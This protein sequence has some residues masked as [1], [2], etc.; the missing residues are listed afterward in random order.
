MSLKLRKDLWLRSLAILL[1]FT[2]TT[3]KMAA[4]VASQTTF[5]SGSATNGT[6]GT[7][8]EYITYTSSKGDGTTK[9]AIYSKCIRLYKPSPDKATGGFITFT[10]KEGATI[11]KVVVGSSNATSAVYKVDDGKLSTEQQITANGSITIPDLSASTVSVYNG[12]KS[13]ANSTRDQQLNINKIEITYTVGGGKDDAGLSFPQTAY[14][15][16]VG[17]SFTAPVATSSAGSTGAITYI[18]SAP[19]VASVDPNTG[20]VEILKRGSTVITATIAETETHKSGTTQYTLTVND[21]NFSGYVLVKSANDLKDGLQFMI[22]YPSTSQSK[23]MGSANSSGYYNAVNVTITDDVLDPGNSEPSIVTLKSAANASNGTPQWYLT[24]SDGKYFYATT[25]NTLNA[26]DTPGDDCV[27]QISFDASGNAIIY[28]SSKTRYL[29]YNSSSPRFACYLSTSNTQK[30]KIYADMSTGVEKTPVTLAFEPSTPVNMVQGGQ[31]EARVLKVT[32]EDAASHVRWESSIPAIAAVDATSGAITMGTQLGT[33]TIKAYIPVN[34]DTYKATEATYTITVTE[35]PKT[36]VTISFPA[37]EYSATVGAAFESP[38][39]TI[40]PAGATGSLAYTSSEPTVASVIAETGVVTPLAAGTTTIKATFTGSGDYANNTAQYVLTVYPGECAAPTFDVENNA[41]VYVGDVIKATC[42]TTGST[43]YINGT[44]A[45]QYTVTS[46][47]LGTLTLTAYAEVQG[48]NGVI[49]SAESSVTL[50]VEDKPIETVLDKSKF[51]DSGLSGSYSS[52]NFTIPPYGYGNILAKTDGTN[53]LAWNTNNT[54]SCGIV[55]N[56][57]TNTDTGYENAEVLYEIKSIKIEGLESGKK[58]NVYSSDTKYAATS[59]ITSSTTSIGQ[60]T[61]TENTYTF[62]KGTKF[63]GLRPSAGG[64]TTFTKITVTWVVAGETVAEPKLRSGEEEVTADGTYYYDTV[65]TMTCADADA[66]LAYGVAETEDGPF[67]MQAY[68][69]EGF[70]I[71]LPEGEQMDSKTF[72]VKGRSEKGSAENENVWSVT[73]R[74][75]VPEFAFDKKVA[76]AYLHEIRAE[77]QAGLVEDEV[78]YLEGITWPEEK[79]KASALESFTTPEI[80]NKAEFENVTYSLD[81][82]EGT[83]VVT[84]DENTGDLT[85]GMRLGKAVVTASFPGND[86]YA[87]ATASYNLVVDVFGP[88]DLE[89]VGGDAPEQVMEFKFATSGDD[90]H[91]L[92]SDTPLDAIFTAGSEYINGIDVTDQFGK[93]S[94][95]Y[96]ASTGGLKIGTRSASGT[97]TFDFNTVMAFNKVEL[98]CKF[99]ND[100]D[101][102]V[103]SVNDQKQTFSMKEGD[104]ETKTVTFDFTRQPFTSLRLSTDKRVSAGDDQRSRLCITDIKITGSFVLPAPVIPVPFIKDVAMGG[105]VYMDPATE[106]KLKFY[107]QTGADIYYYYDSNVDVQDPNQAGI[108]SAPARAEG[109]AVTETHVDA[110]G[111]TQTFTKIGNAEEIPANKGLYHFYAKRANG[112]DSILESEVEVIGIGVSTPTGIGNAV[113]EGGKTAYFTLQGVRVSKPTTGGIYIRVRDGK[114]DK[115]LLK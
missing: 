57:Y 113:V 14:T 17:D 19:T 105:Y 55:I 84:I 98:T 4:D 59:S 11:T 22:G 24:T 45:N 43:L 62:K 104:E 12:G 60:L 13:S 49:R 40:E 76:K 99:Y 71:A 100:E 33:T 48:Q 61:P 38:V 8:G 110:V 85:F 75:H 35:K 2:G 50:T 34:D 25:G 107:A 88:E 5:M 70:T 52:K 16:N 69:A 28:Y 86:R 47:D 73:I 94:N 106:D 21:P 96:Y 103:L 44:A 7:L 39:A 114:A 93:N 74:K 20:A 56:A 101:E 112:Q 111:K 32:P 29:Q 31:P 109:E 58:I 6:S 36:P 102:T 3:V 42:A 18:S 82:T 26:K 54:S 9:P 23:A 80:V 77:I 37:A 1:M 91:A 65:F 72:Y 63:V 90:T 27:A 53:G 41:T 95:V 108:L 51:S 81:V 89:D 66:T 30:V 46:A 68:P 115:V 10:A 92:F 79:V 78:T 87:A 64:L 83:D 15:V 67:E 97:V